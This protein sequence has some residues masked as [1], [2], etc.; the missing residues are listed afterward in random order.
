MSEGRIGNEPPSSLFG[1]VEV[2]EFTHPCR[3]CR[4]TNVV[5]VHYLRD[6]FITGGGKKLISYKDETIKDLADTVNRQ[7]KV[8]Q[9]L[10]QEVTERREQMRRLFA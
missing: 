10:L 4:T 6:D 3:T 9:Q 2:E 1:V 8:I 7:A 5:R